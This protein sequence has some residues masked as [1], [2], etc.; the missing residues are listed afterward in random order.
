MTEFLTKE[1][2]VCGEIVT[3]YSCDG[4]RW[5]SSRTEAEQ[6]ERRREK[7]YA[8]M[9]RTL[10]ESP[11]FVHKTRRIGRATVGPTQSK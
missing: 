5:T 2:V 6:C 7:F 11:T 1:I 10:K 3:V 9:Q 4:W 8:H